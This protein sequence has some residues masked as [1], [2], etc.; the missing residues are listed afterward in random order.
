MEN[1]EPTQTPATTRPTRR[2]HKKVFSGCWTCRSKH[3]KCDEGKPTCKRCERSGIT[4]EGYGV[5]LSWSSH[6]DLTNFQDSPKRSSPRVSARRGSARK[7]RTP[8]PRPTHNASA[9]N[10]KESAEI[11]STT[12]LPGEDDGLEN[13]AQNNLRAGSRFQVGIDS[14]EVETPANPVESPASSNQWDTV[15]GSLSAVWSRTTL[16]PNNGAAIHSPV[17][18][19][20]S[21]AQNVISL[22]QDPSPRPNTE[23]SNPYADISWLPPP[24]QPGSCSS[25]SAVQSP[26]SRGPTSSERRR[27]H[28]DSLSD[29]ASRS[30]LLEH[31]DLHVCDALNP[32]SGAT[33]PA[34]TIFTPLA[35]QGARE[36]ATVSTGAVAL[37]HLICSSSG[38]HLARAEA[39]S[40][41]RNK[42]ERLALEH[43]NLG[44][45]HL[46]RNIQSDDESQYIPVLASLIMC[47]LN[48]AI[49][50]YDPFWRLHIQGAVEWVNHVGREYW[51]H[52]E[53]A[54]TI[55]QMFIGM[56]I[57]IQSQILPGDRSGYGWDL[58]HAFETQPGPYCLD[59]IMGIPQPILEVI[60]TMNRIQQSSQKG[61]GSSE[62][63]PSQQEIDPNYSLDSLEFELFLMVPKRSISPHASPEHGL[64]IYHLGYAYYYATLLYLKRTMKSVPIQEVQSLV[65]QGL[66]HIEALGA[67]NG[68]SSPNLWPIAIIAFE[69]YEPL[70]QQRMIR[71]LEE[72]TKVSRLE[73]W[74]K[75]S[76]A[77]RGLWARRR[78]PGETNLSWHA[79]SPVFYH[80]YIFI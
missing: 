80:N 16:Q 21:L 54:A 8:S 78:S 64:R 31:W 26:A 2:R 7:S 15:R 35:L 49:T 52:D 67:T 27:R 59:V 50:V 77:V 43:Q 17:F 38:F 66:E 69:A 40:G 9:H 63:H 42:Y 6:R 36:D 60:H 10:E 56:G 19:T 28:L 34:R 29:H 24:Q 65:K 51:H 73:V 30:K 79:Y 75:F 58:C 20:E 4:C 25:N 71:C 5:R 44:I 46:S 53:T 70:L 23:S 45:T 39:T 1:D 74:D 11:S 22:R 37:F 62:D 76:I 47:L 68:P 61:P 32:I 12:G 33:N 55:Y 18:Q 14:P 13:T 3:I 57:L 41:T 72:L 48:E